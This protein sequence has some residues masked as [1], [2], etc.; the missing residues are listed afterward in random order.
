[1]KGFQYYSCNV[2]DTA[3]DDKGLHVVNP[4]T[5]EQ[6][7]FLY[8]RTSVWLKP[9]SQLSVELAVWCGPMEARHECS[10]GSGYIPWLG[11]GMNRGEPNT[12]MD[13]MLCQL[14]VGWGLM[15]I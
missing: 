7:Y 12:D 2:G 6:L 10:S 5:S 1:M 3:G 13:A 8:L 9:T 14:G 15:E 11:I 4:E